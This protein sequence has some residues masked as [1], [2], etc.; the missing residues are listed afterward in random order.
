MRPYLDTSALVKLYD[1]DPDSA[2]VAD[3]VRSNHAPFLVTSLHQFELTNALALKVRR[4]ETSAV[5][6]AEWRSLFASDLRLGI[7]TPVSPEWTSVWKQGEELSTQFT[8]ELGTRSLDVLHVAIALELSCT[9][10]LTNDVRQAE[11][12]RGLD[13]DVILV[14]DLVG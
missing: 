13:L 14:S 5:A 4:G 8:P 12:S 6:F 9:T 7:L 2:Q 1:P 11:L 3:W 10:I